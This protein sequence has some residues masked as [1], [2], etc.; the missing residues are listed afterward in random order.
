MSGEEKAAFPL[1]RLLHPRGP[2]GGDY[3]LKQKIRISEAPIPTKTAAKNKKSGCGMR[4]ALL[5]AASSNHL[6]LIASSSLF[7]KYP[8]HG[9]IKIMEG[10]TEEYALL[11]GLGESPGGGDDAA[12]SMS[13]VTG[14]VVYVVRIPLVWFQAQRN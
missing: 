2:P 5:P 3:R 14:Q 8:Q 12:N 10:V 11:A 1:F 7:E 4:R 9:T 13:R 6:P